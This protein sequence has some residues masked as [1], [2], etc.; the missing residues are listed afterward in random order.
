MILNEFHVM[1]FGPVAKVRD[2]K[3]A[4]R[5]WIK[6]HNVKGFSHLGRQMSL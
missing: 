1:S 4:A 6:G 5:K 2:E 3:I